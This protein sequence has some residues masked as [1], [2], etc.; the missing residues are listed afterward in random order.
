[1][2]QKVITLGARTHLTYKPGELGQLAHTFDEMAETLKIQEQ[3]IANYKVGWVEE[4]NPTYTIHL[5]I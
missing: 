1:M 5:E 4:R 2:L 3:A